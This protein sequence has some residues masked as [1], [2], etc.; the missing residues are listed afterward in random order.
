MSLGGPCS[1]Y[2][3]CMIE[4]TRFPLAVATVLHRVAGSVDQA[5]AERGA[6]EALAFLRE[7]FLANRSLKLMLDLRGMHFVTLQAHRAWSQNF[8]RHPALQ[9]LVHAVAIIGDDTPA[10]RSEQALLE[11]ERVHFFVDTA[12][13]TVWLGRMSEHSQ[14]YRHDL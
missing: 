6:A 14:G 3:P 2:T 10:F 7:L 11:T 13:A 9:G 8:A 4:T 1:C 12:T 5:E